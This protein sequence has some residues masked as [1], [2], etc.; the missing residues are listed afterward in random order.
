MNENKENDQKKDD[1]YIDLNPLLDL[2][3]ES[4]KDVKINDIVESNNKVKVEKIEADKTFNNRNLIFWKWKFVKDLIIVFL[5]LTTIFL[6]SKFGIIEGSIVGTLLGS[7]IGY[8]IGNGFSK[9]KK[10]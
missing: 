9:N 3:K 4:L 1:E 8:S 2:I 10:D 5:I 7:V 6:L